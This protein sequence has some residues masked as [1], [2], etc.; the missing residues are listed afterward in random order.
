MSSTNHTTNYN[1]PQYVGSDKP[2]WLG[3][4]NPAFSAIDS[5]MKANETSASV[6]G[7]DATTANNNIGT[8]ANLT[9]D[10]KTTLVGAINEVDTI[11]GTA[12]GTAN[13]AV[14]D[15]SAVDLK[16]NNFMQKFNLS[17][18]TNASTI[19]HTGGSV[20]GKFT[21]AQNSD[22][23]I[24]KVYGTMELSG[25]M[26]VT[27]WTQIAGMTG[28]YG[29]PSGLFLTTAPSEA[30]F[31]NTG[32]VNYYKGTG[33]VLHMDDNNIAVGTDGQIYVWALTWQPSSQSVASGYSQTLI[34]PACVY[35]N[36][37]FGDTPSPDE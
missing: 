17:N 9:T 23:S 25:Q 31:I 28:K 33:N 22:G 37:D 12:Q 35:F 34:L 24:F 36:T 29:I 3:D 13:Q 32:G 6:A 27:G 18:I 7:A 2:A 4:I 15:A 11:A 20:I 16:L 5:A 10:E 30:Y 26:S 8:M 1:L 21:L 14:S 19:P